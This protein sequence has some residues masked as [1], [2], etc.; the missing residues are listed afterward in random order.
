MFKSFILQCLL[1]KTDIEFYKILGIIIWIDV[2]LTIVK[3]LT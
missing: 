2:L 1:F 3:I